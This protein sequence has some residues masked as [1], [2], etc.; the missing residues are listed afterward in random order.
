MRGHHIKRPSLFSSEELIYRMV[1]HIVMASLANMRTESQAAHLPAAAVAVPPATRVRAAPAVLPAA[2]TAV[3]P[4]AVRAAA[5]L[6]AGVHKKA[7]SAGNEGVDN[8]S[9]ATICEIDSEATIC[10]SDSEETIDDYG[11][12]TKRRKRTHD[13]ELAACRPSTA[14]DRCAR[15]AA[16]WRQLCAARARAVAKK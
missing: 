2:A 7:A 1:T 9:E 8:D 6:H 10:E 16:I 5:V 12:A 4:A 15:R 11:E 3:P 14:R 13:N